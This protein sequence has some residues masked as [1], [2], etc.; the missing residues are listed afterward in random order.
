MPVLPG[1]ATATEI[2]MALDAGLDCVKFFP[3]EAARWAE[4]VSSALAAP[5]ATTRFVP[6]GGITAGTLPAYAV[7]PRCWPWVAAGWWRPTCLQSGRFDEVYGWLP[8]R[9]PKRPSHGLP[10]IVA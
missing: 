7:T 4:G 5:F 6:T 1:V 9:S 10:S 3:A 2:L 8:R